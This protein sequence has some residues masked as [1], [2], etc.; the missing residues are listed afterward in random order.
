MRKWS[1]MKKK[2]LYVIIAFICISL[3]GIVAVQYFWINN[4]IQVKEAQ[5]DRSV[6]EAMGVVVNKL[7]TREDIVYL[8]K[9]LVGD[10][11]HALVQA[12][13]KDPILALN[14]KLDSLLRRDED[15]RPPFPQRRP[16]F[17]EMFFDENLNATFA[18][19][20]NVIRQYRHID[21]FAQDY[22]NG[23]TI[24]WNAEFDGNRLDSIIL[25]NRQRIESVRPRSM[26]PAPEQLKVLRKQQ[27]EMRRKN[28]MPPPPENSAQLY[29]EHSREL[30]RPDPAIFHD[31]MRIIT[32]KARKIKDVIQKMAREMENKPL[33]IEKR[34]NR[35]NL[36]KSLSKALADKDIS[37]PY[38]YAVITSSPGNNK[39][40]LR[41][42]GFQIDK[43]NQIHRVSL[44]PNDI[45]RK[46]NTLLLYFP[47]Q[48]SI[49]LKSL[50]GL[51]LVSV[52]FTLIIVLSSILGIVT[53]LRQKKISDIK[54]DFINNMTHEFKTPIA[55]ISIAVD[56]INNAKVIDEPERIKSFTRIIKEENNRM[57]ARVEQ[58]LQMALLDS[59]EF[60]LNLKS[61]DLNALV[62]KV[63]G[64][65]RLQVE[66]REGRLELQPD[67]LNSLVEAD[68]IHLSNVIMNLLDN[69]NKYSPGKPEIRVTTTNRGSSVM[70][71]VEDKG[72]GM[73]T[74][75]Q[76]K[77]FE[78]FY[79][80]TNGN[81]HNVKGFGLGLSYARAI[82]LAHKGEIKVTSEAGKGSTFVVTLPVIADELMS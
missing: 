11:I 45:F 34:I 81:I 28:R 2:V 73:N 49:V 78:K 30:N 10:S 39:V 52:F 20:D 60:R 13:S 3:A 12:F 63:A 69:A 58:V 7:E 50:S 48:K 51:M 46:T 17:P 54:T 5:F 23:F 37:S 4:A 27:K 59:S 26:S 66:N 32:K 6:N 14:D 8:R 62:T 1:G 71:T 80:L 57:N 22:P 25:A 79:R 68:E 21:V 16:P 38:E 40:P 41:S 31:D 75:T 9:N 15:I 72:M 36:E 53:M 77:I 65:I 55:T 70:V 33:P 76:R 44:F 82:V 18:D 74:E 64:N 43:R 19:L 29:I 24:E 56:S 47:E 42:G 61:V 67:A 35:E